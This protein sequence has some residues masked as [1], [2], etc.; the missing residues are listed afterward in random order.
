MGDVNSQI[1]T[2]G[3]SGAISGVLGAYLLLHPRAQ[4]L[5]AIPFG[6]FIHTTRLPA[7]LVLAFWF[8]LQL[9]NSAA[10]SAGES[11]VAWG[12]HIG[13]FVAGMALIPLFKS[14]NV[15]LFTQHTK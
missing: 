1:P 13:G 15:K 9:I 2:V 4:V 8:V 14:R 5:V 10:A 12:A 3:A 11:G 7:G 6:F